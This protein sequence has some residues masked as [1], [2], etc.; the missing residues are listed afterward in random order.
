MIWLYRNK[1]STYL[2]ND[3]SIGFGEIPAP[4]SK[5]TRNFSLFR[6]NRHFVTSHLTKN[7]ASP[8]IPDLRESKVKLHKQIPFIAPKTQ[9]PFLPFPKVAQARPTPEEK[10]LEKPGKKE[11]IAIFPW[12]QELKNPVCDFLISGK[13]G[14]KMRNPKKIDLRNIFFIF[15][16]F[17]PSFLACFVSA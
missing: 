10:K 16:L 13:N 2:I 8:E 6:P 1:K 15:S 17:L 5:N 3:Q 9:Y 7:P 14:G 4:E 12:F 11:G